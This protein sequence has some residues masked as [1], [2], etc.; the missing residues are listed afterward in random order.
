M[1]ALETTVTASINK[2]NEIAPEHGGSDER[3]AARIRKEQGFLAAVRNAIKVKE[4]A[5]K[6]ERDRASKEGL[7]KLPSL[8]ASASWGETENGR[9]RVLSGAGF[10]AWRRGCVELRSLYA[11]SLHTHRVQESVEV[12]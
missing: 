12:G 8:P 4:E 5:L 7:S 2:R 3:H 6:A 11:D 9:S 1:R 10:V